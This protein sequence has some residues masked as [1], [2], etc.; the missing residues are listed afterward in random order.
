MSIGNINNDGNKGRNFPWQLKM[1]LGQQCACDQLTA[2][3]QDAAQ[4]NGNTDQVEY[5]LTAILT[6]LQSGTEYEAKFVL[7]TCDANKLYLEVR[8]WNTDTGT[9]GPITYY[10]PGS[11]TPVVPVNPSAPCLQ[12]S[13]PSAVLGLVLAELQTQTG[14]LTDIEADTTSIDIT[15]TSILAAYSAGQQACANSLSVTLCTEQGQLLTDIEA[16]TESA[17]TS[18]TNID[19]TTS[20]ILTEVL[21]QGTTLDSIETELLDQGTTLD[22]IETELLD[23]GTTLDTIS[24]NVIDIETLITTLNSIVSTEATLQAV[25]TELQGINIDTNGLSQEATQLLVLAAINSVISN[26]TGLAQEVTLNALLTAFNA[27]DF[28][29][30][31]TLANIETLTNA[32][33]V[34]FN[35]EDFAT[36]TTL[37][38]LLASFNAEDFATESTLAALNAWVQANAATETTLQAVLTELQGINIDTNGLSQEATQLLVLA[39]LNNILTDTANLDVPLST[40]ATEVTL[41]AVLNALTNLATSGLATEATL[42]NLYN[43]FITEDFATE[44]TL[45]LIE[46]ITAQMTFTVND[47]NVSANMQVGDVDVSAANPVPVVLPVGSETPNYVEFLGPTPPSSTPGG[48]KSVSLFNEGPSRWQLS[49]DGGVTWVNF[50]EGQIVEWT[51]SEGKTLNGIL[52]RKI[53]IGGRLIM[54]YSI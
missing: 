31:T 17:A 40:L 3:A 38:S 5:L 2:I 48:A 35:A 50:N 37:A 8:V 20:N 53:D 21:D 19:T 1:L 25:L 13:D 11:S 33:L 22:S 23:Q 51:A 15:L 24:T 54:S 32:L 6:T 49:S 18:L 28:A 41:Q 46:S 16:N 44:T 39:A 4:I 43:A 7:D 26:T 9:W 36:E 45:A 30:E 34:A 47:L 42:L 10:I 29:T 12:Y 14:I 27:E 52:F